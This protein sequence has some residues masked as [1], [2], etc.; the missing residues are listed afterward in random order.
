MDN[1]N[2]NN[3]IGTPERDDDVMLPEGYNDESIF[4][5]PD[6]DDENIF[7]TED[8]IE[9]FGDE[10]KG[11][12]DP[13]PEE[14][15]EKSEP[16]KEDGVG[17]GSEEGNA[18][19]VEQ[20][21]EA[22]SLFKI[23]DGDQEVELKEGDVSELY[24]F[25]KEHAGIN[26]R[27]QELQAGMDEA[28]AMA[29]RL[30]FG[31]FKAMLAHAQD[32]YRDAEIKRLT[33]DPDHPVHP[34]VAKAIVES[35]MRENAA[36]AASAAPQQ[37][38]QKPEAGTAMPPQRNFRQEVDDLL[39]DRPQL[40][41]ELSKGGRLPQEVISNAAK[42]GITLRAAYAEYEAGEVKKEAERMKQENTILKQ[43]AEARA[44]APVK[45]VS[46]GGHVETKGKDPFLLGFESDN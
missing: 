19:A 43:N 42:S 28:E 38:E 6:G 36:K 2:L 21:Q 14:E 39:A 44:K 1:E 20:K 25:K 46:T 24:H 9:G 18:P 41:E 12:E 11:E 32:T 10:G 37:Q 34:E 31:D 22:G 40:R 35:K 26:G 29:K 13:A 3:E 15:P 5:E 8:T 45:G 33:E 23:K 16:Q 30:G 7:G 27:L 17:A 4:A